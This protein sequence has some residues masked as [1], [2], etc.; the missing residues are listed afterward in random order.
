MVNTKKYRLLKNKMGK[1]KK[2]EVFG[3]KKLLYIMIN[4][5]KLYV[6]SKGKMMKLSKYK[7]IKKEE[8]KKKVE[9]KKKVQKK[10]KVDKKGGTRRIYGQEN[11]NPN[12]DRTPYWTQP[13]P[14]YTPITPITPITP[15]TPNTPYTPFTPNTPNYVPTGTY[16]P[17][18]G[19]PISYP[20]YATHWQP[21]REQIN[22]LRNSI[23]ESSDD[24]N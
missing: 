11:L 3:V 15:N 19:S 2:I 21:T 5:K 6:I 9:K 22:A 20:A 14:S 7:K 23:E 18:H 12:P 17:S 8:V 1:N 10:K 24:E 13:T 16:Y 4:T